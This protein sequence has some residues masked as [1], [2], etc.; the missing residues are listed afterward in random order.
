MEL[1]WDEYN[2]EHASRHGVSLI[3]ITDMAAHGPF[4]ELTHRRYPGQKRFVGLSPRNR[5]ITVAVEP[6]EGRGRARPVAA[7]PSTVRE[8]ALYWEGKR[9]YG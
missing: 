5:F 2:R 9:R 4:V 1:I 3:E 8:I 7:W 6:V